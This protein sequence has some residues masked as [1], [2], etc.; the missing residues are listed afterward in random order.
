MDK[1]GPLR[2]AYSGQVIGAVVD[3]LGLNRGA[4]RS[5]TARRFFGGR[6]VSEDKRTE[7]L[8]ELGEILIDRG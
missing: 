1:L 8:R 2:T 3:A 4:L 7:F 5:R 6:T